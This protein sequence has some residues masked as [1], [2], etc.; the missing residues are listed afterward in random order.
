MFERA[1]YDPETEK[2]YLVFTD[3]PQVINERLVPSLRVH[4]ETPP[5]GAEP[6]FQDSPDEGIPQ[7]PPL[8]DVP[9]ENESTETPVEDVTENPE[10]DKPL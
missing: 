1:E 7:Q 5:Y 2:V 10:D 4:V 9:S 3:T 8:D 6:I